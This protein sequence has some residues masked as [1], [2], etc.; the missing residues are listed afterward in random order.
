VAYK[1]SLI[2]R[3]QGGMKN[4]FS[5]G[6]LNFSSGGRITMGLDNVLDNGFDIVV[7]KGVFRMGN[8]NYFNSN[9]K[10]V[11]FDAITIGNDC[12][13]A[14][15]VHLYDHDHRFE[16]LNHPIREQGY[17]TKPI[18]I[19]NNVWIGAKATVLKGVT[20]A[21]GAIIGAN[22][23]VTRDVPANAIVGGNPGRIIKIRTSLK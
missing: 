23:V 16:D 8:R 13:I 17:K 12:L 6:R 4:Y 21:D 22:S 11:C 9:V 15:S 3:L 18:T 7:E 1:I 19:G 14:D 10:I 2:G 5:Q 20:I